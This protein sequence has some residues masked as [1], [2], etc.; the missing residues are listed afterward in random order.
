MT[1]I[2][3]DWESNPQRF[4]FQVQVLNMEASKTEGRA[5]EIQVDCGRMTK[6]TFRV[7]LWD[8]WFAPWLVRTS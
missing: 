5:L 3:V 6:R 8:F 7:G 2:H 4:C 1:R